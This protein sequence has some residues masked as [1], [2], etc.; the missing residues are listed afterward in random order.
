MS[1][2]WRRLQE[3]FHAAAELSPERRRSFVEESCP[4]DPGLRNEVLA[5]LDSAQN[6]EDLASQ[7][8]AAAAAMAADGAPLG[9]RFGPYRLEKEL[10]SSGMGRVFL[11]ARDDDVFRKRVALKIVPAASGPDLLARFRSERQILASLEHPNIARL[12]DGGANEDGIPYLVMEYV[13]GEAI[14]VYCDRQRLGVRERLLLFEGVCRAV[15]YAHQNLVVHRDLKP[16]N[17]MVTAEGQVKLLDFGIAKLL[18]PELFPALAPITQAAVRPMTPEYASPEQIRGEPVTTASDVFSLGIVL[19]ELLTGQRPFRASGPTLGE[20]ERLISQTEPQRPSTAVVQPA[21]GPESPEGPTPEEIGRLRGTLPER[22]RRELRGDVDNIVLMAL[23]KEPARRYASAEQMAEDLGR[24]RE[25]RP[26]LARTD[27][28]VYR[29]G[30]FMQRNRIGVATAATLVMLLVGFAAN[31]WRLAQVLL[32]ERDRA[33]VE[34]ESARR[35]ERMLGDIFESMNPDGGSGRSAAV[36]DVLERER[37]R[38]EMELRDDPA[39]LAALQNRL[40]EIY[41]SLEQYDRALP[42]LEGALAARRRV[43]GP[44]SLETAASLENL[45]E[46]QNE[47]GEFEAAEAFLREALEVEEKLLGNEDPEVADTQQ[48]LGVAR[49]GLGDW[50]EAE[51]RFRRAL[52]IRDRERGDHPDTAVTLASLAQLV[53]EEGRDAE[54]EA[55]ARRA[56][57]IQRKEWGSRHLEVA[58]ALDAL[59]DVLLC[60]G[61]VAA[62]RPPLREGLEIRRQLGADHPVL[63]ASQYRLARLQE[64]DGDLA[65]AEASYRDALAKLVSARGEG[66]PEAARVRSALGGVLVRSGKLGEARSLLDGALAF[67]QRLGD[68]NLSTLETRW[69]LGELA[70]A[71]GDLDEAE[72]LFTGVIASW[73]KALPSPSPAL[74]R[75]LVAL[76]ALRLDQRRAAEAEPLLREG[77]DLWKSLRPEHAERGR[78]EALLGQCLVALGKDAEGEDLLTAGYKRLTSGLG[79]ETLD[80]RLA[81]KS[82][83][84]FY[85][86]RGRRP[87]APR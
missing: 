30:K 32:L 62:A 13:E 29:T 44:A 84:T 75:S 15:H 64:S 16:S 50:A 51:K 19:Y 2:S 71:R 41:Q 87:P 9:Q 49:R 21:R 47:R 3:L 56:V 5:M 66:H 59:V 11:A 68:S 25:G 73:R 31:R 28:F 20:L 42:L 67:Q 23:R 18:R 1:E 12:L 8:Q 78:A 48:A 58:R 27:T 43:L 24:Y 52:E 22:L 54:A 35:V 38:F 57:G 76:G 26:L 53:S 33:R 80:A 36:L 82:L 6:S 55:L 17:I 77:L 60:Q 40:G 7:V 34:A 39:V 46:V 10:H 45:G 81:R 65:A 69:R 85:E 4:D 72:T 63:W 61:D 83:V 74:A 37:E 14:D 70:V 86:A 79:H